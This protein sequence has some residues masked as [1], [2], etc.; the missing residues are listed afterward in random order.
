M[1]FV[2]PI[3]TELLHQIF[4]RFDRIITVE[5]GVI[6]GGFGSAV[7]EFMSDHGYSARVV[8]LGVPDH[9]IEQGKPEELTDECGFGFGG[10]METARQLLG[11]S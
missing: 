9:F 11:N 1:R 10:I 4:S 2:K 8:R 7:L 3:D 5:D 6:E